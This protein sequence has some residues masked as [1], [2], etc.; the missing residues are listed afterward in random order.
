MLLATLA[1]CRRA[2]RGSQRRLYSLYYSY[3]MSICLRYAGTRD[4]AMEA[5]N[6]GFMKVFRDVSH[7]DPTK[8]E[9]SGSFRG[10]LRKI[11][12]HT[13][14]DHY[15]A[16]EKHQHQQDLDKTAYALAD[17]GGSAL[18]S[19]S[20]D[21]LLHMIHQLPPAYRTAFN[22][23]VIDGFTHEEI[24]NRLHISVGTSKSNLSKARAHLK[25]L[26]KKT[27]HHAYAGNVG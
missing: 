1:G 4:E 11:M 13:A 25:D 5:V 8:H 14:I 18:D 23:Y 10:W 6:D 17:E 3:S 27:S 24:A 9:T 7:F 20:Y 22:L 2:D 16:Q 26:L 15:R 19:L 12:I 21:E